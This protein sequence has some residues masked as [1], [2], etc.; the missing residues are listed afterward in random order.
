M[1]ART[2]PLKL[3][4]LQLRTLAILQAIARTE[5]M[6]GPA[7]ENGAVPILHI[8]RPHG[9]HFHIG[10][11]VVSS[12]DASGLGNPAVFGA[13]E[14]KGLV[15]ASPEGRPMLTATGVGYETGL[16]KGLLHGADH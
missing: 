14:R 15:A 11:A 6:A 5:G 13:L 2:N 9:D 16:G 1:T 7:D 3:N 8:P 4:P 10:A 12:R